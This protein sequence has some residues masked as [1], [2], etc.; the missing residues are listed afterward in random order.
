M[1]NV[2]PLITLNRYQT[3][4]LFSVLVAEC[5]IRN[6]CYRFV[7][8]GNC[9]FGKKCHYKHE[10]LIPKSPFPH[11]LTFNYYT[12]PISLINDYHSKSIDNL[13]Y[14]SFQQYFSYSHFFCSRDFHPFYLDSFHLYSVPTSQTQR[15]MSLSNEFSVWGN[16]QQNKRNDMA[17]LHRIFAG[18]SIFH[19]PYVPKMKI[20]Q[21][22]SY[23]NNSH[24]P[25]QTDG[26]D[27]ERVDNESQKIFKSISLKEHFSEETME[28]K[29]AIHRIDFIRKSKDDPIAPSPITREYINPYGVIGE[30]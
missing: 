25:I 28:F 29:K 14:L 26:E 18:N 10:P 13:S 15:T 1:T 19:M 4:F 2:E 8:N 12:L 7:L 16:L 11:S 27:F 6:L 17:K 9:R 21:F 22:H 30:K 3:H 23:S 5:N 24:V 20:S